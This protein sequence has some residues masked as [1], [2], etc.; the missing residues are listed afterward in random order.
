[1]L[2]DSWTEISEGYFGLEDDSWRIYLRIDDAGGLLEVYEG[3]ILKTTTSW[4]PGVASRSGGTDWCKKQSIKVLEA[5]KKK[6]S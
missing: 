2:M 5:E 3:T 6:R 1:M 4:G